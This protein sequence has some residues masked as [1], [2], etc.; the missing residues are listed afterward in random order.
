[1]GQIAGVCFHHPHYSSRIRMPFFATA[2][3]VRLSCCSFPTLSSVEDEESNL[4]PRRRA[5]HS[6]RQEQWP[7]RSNHLDYLA[8]SKTSGSTTRTEM[9]LHHGQ[10]FSHAYPANERCV[11]CDESQGHTPTDEEMCRSSYSCWRSCVYDKRGTSAFVSM[12]RSQRAKLEA[13]LLPVR[14]MAGYQ[15]RG[16]AMFP[17]L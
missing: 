14:K 6:G 10:R 11:E 12:P 4:Q 7:A 8:R 13:R 3:R 16:G 2:P 5:Y 1:M 9:I 15:T 17:L